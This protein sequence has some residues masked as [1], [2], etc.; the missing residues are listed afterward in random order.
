[1]L[2]SALSASMRIVCAC[3][4]RMERW[5]A[6]VS[7]R[8]ALD[9]GPNAP[10]LTV[11][12]DQSPAG[13]ATSRDQIDQFRTVVAG[14][15]TRTPGRRCR[16]A[17]TIVYVFDE[18]TPCASSCRS[19]E[20]ER[21]SEVAELFQGDFGA[22]ASSSRRSSDSGAPRRSCS[23]NTRTCSCAMPVRAPSAWLG[24]D[25]PIPQVICQLSS[26]AAKVAVIGRPVPDHIQ[27]L[28]DN[29]IPLAERCSPWTRRLRSTTRAADDRSST[30]NHGRWRTTR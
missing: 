18:P 11:I 8:A 9:D 17:A 21:D 30:P 22:G 15:I 14:L 19:T 26:P 3:R 6:G 4:R 28:R 27:L 25:S 10:T 5:R 13:S 16:L 23:T 12:G 20:A 29:Y 1:M 2:R 7:R 24:G